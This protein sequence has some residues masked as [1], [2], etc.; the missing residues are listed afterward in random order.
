[1]K[2]YDREKG[3]ERHD[4]ASTIYIY[5]T[6]KYSTIQMSNSTVLYGVG[7]IGRVFYSTGPQV[8]PSEKCRV[9]YIEHT[10]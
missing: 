10:V 7:Y 2:K 8:P 3:K 4:S 6:V 1:V 5:G 9:W